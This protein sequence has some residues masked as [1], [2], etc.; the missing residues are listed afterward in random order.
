MNPAAKGR[1]RDFTH[2]LLEQRILRRG[3][4]R[5]VTVGA[6]ALPQQAGGIVGDAAQNFFRRDPDVVEMDGTATGARLADPIPVVGELHA[7]AIDRD[8]SRGQLAVR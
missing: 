8:T 3:L 1:A 5:C 4:N 6:V 7:G 2:D